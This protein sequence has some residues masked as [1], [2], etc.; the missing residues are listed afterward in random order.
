MVLSRII[1]NRFIIILFLLSITRYHLIILICYSLLFE[2]LS[3]KVLGATR[4]WLEG[5]GSVEEGEEKRERG[6][7]EEKKRRTHP[8]ETRLLPRDQSRRPRP[9]I[10]IT[11]ILFA[12]LR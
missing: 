6:K 12:R 8:R 3:V 1:V 9:V 4:K 7:G 10:I 5:G 2:L 11:T